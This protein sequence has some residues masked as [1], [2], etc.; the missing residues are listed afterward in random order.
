MGQKFMCK[1]GFASAVR[2]GDDDNLGGD[3][4]FFNLIKLSDFSRFYYARDFSAACFTGA[5]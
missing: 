5:L 1:G 4:H 3:D 2:A